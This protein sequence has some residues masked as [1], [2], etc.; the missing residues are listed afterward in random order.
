M[1]WFFNLKTGAKLALSFGVCLALSSSVGIVSIS[2]LNRMKQN[3]DHIVNNALASSIEIGRLNATARKFRIYEMRHITEDKKG[4]EKDLE[5]MQAA[6]E[7]MNKLF[8]AYDKTCHLPED[9]QNF[10]A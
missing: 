6:T 7:K 9:R 8:S 2:C 1:N 4:Q 3:T 10:D 5:R